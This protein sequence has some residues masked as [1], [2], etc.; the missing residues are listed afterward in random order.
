MCPS[1]TVPWWTMTARH[2]NQ[3]RTVLRSGKPCPTAKRQSGKGKRDPKTVY[4]RAERTR[5]KLRS[6]TVSVGRP[7]G[8]YRPH[9]L[10]RTSRSGVRLYGNPLSRQPMYSR[11]LPSL[12]C[13]RFPAEFFMPGNC[14]HMSSSVGNA[15]ICRNQSRQIAMKEQAQVCEEAHR[16]LF[17]SLS[18]ILV[19]SS[20]TARDFG[21]KL[22]VT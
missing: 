6:S 13:A 2:L 21:R 18:I 4:L 12:R 22:R 14:C 7:Q 10:E 19:S 5:R 17:R 8:G 1:T 16:R 15:S 20:W 3:T 9:P 11:R